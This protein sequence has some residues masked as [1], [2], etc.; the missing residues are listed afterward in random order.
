MSSE[1]YLEQ[2]DPPGTRQVGFPHAL[3]GRRNPIAPDY[4]GALPHLAYVLY[5]RHAFDEAACEAEK[6]IG[7]DPGDP[8]AWGILGAAYLEVGKHVEAEDAYQNMM[9]LGADLYS[10]RRL[11]GLK[12]LRRRRGEAIRA[13]G[14]LGVSF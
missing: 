4:G 2:A 6:A 14:L 9:R 10:W 13:T 3:A 5:P 8:H 11:S 1:N 12:S 7:A